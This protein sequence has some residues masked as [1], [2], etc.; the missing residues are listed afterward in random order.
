MISSYRLFT[1]KRQIKK[2]ITVFA[3]LLVLTAAFGIINKSFD[4]GWFNLFISSFLPIFIMCM[5]PSLSIVTLSMVYNANCSDQPNGY[6]YLHS[7]PNSTRHFQNAV[8]FGNIFSLGVVLSDCAVLAA[9]FDDALQMAALVL[10]GLG[11][12]NFTAYVKNVIFRILPLAVV[13]GIV[14]FYVGVSQD[15]AEDGENA[16]FTVFF[17]IAAIVAAVI[18]I[19]GT[20]YAVLNAKRAWNKE[21]KKCAD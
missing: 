14:G 12:L 18:Y 3:V 4:F 7:I 17:T 13:G 6:K 5:L 20:A 10:F 15:V 2:N 11:F 1:E 21:D 9:F 8:V 19:A 16:D